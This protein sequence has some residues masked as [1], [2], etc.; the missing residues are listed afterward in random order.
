M[1]GHFTVLDW[2]VLLAYFGG[3]MS[4]GFYFWRK[5]RS[6]EG[7]TAAERSLPGWVVGLS[8]FATYLSSI[9]YLALPGKSFAGNWNPFVFS[10]AIPVAVWIG[11]KWFVPYYRKSGEVSAYAMLE[12]R[13]GVWARVYVSAFY[14][15]TQVARIGVVTYLMALPMQVI[16]GWDIYTVIIVTGVSVT[17]YS[18]VGGILAV[19]WA[20]AMQAL[21]LMVGA[22]VCLIVLLFSLPDGPGQVFT[23]A[24]E[25]DKFSLGSYSLSDVSTATF[26]VMLLN[27]LFINLQNFGIDQNFCQRYIAAKSDREAKKSLYLGG[28]LYV[29]I[30]ALFFFIGTTLYTYYT[31]YPD[32]IP[33]VKQIVAKQQ[34]L[35]QGVEPQYVEAA[36]DAQAFTPAYQAQLDEKMAGLDNSKIGDR[37][38]P[39]FIAVHLPPGITGLLIAAIFAAGMSTTATSLN[40]SATLIMTDYYKRFINKRAGEK[41]AMIALYVGTILWGILGTGTALALVSKTESALDMWWKMSSIFSGGM[42]SLFLLGMISRRAGN[43]AA[44]TGVIVG[45]LVIVWMVFSKTSLWPP[46]WE[47]ARSPF[48]D[49]MVIVVGTLSIMLVGLIVSR[50]TKPHQHKPALEQYGQS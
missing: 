39:H 20:D 16:F 48:H 14:L 31:S 30:S 37:V 44:V 41:Q 33:Q 42:V 49:F 47:A 21:V 23:V 17:V 18:F 7:F 12:H 43:P 15:L 9:S 10:L 46:A 1:Q 2:I 6:T 50:F 13:F 34:L 38:F 27:G 22:V 32:E 29:P 35:Q 25:H 8:I 3:T 5:S 4:I 40:S 24:A 19:I 28:L 26:W 11:V 45:G 36:G